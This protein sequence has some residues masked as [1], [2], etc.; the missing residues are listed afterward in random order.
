M[1]MA[2]SRGDRS[3]RQDDTHG[4][5]VVAD[6][7]I[8]RYW[9]NGALLCNAHNSAGALCEGIAIR[10]KTK[11]RKHGGLSLSGRASPTYKHGRYSKDLLTGMAAR[12]DEARG[13]PE[14]LSVSDDIALIEARIAEVLRQLGTGESGAAWQDLQRTLAEFQ[15]ALARGDTAGMN[16]HFTQMQQLVQAGSGTARA[17]EELRRLE[18][19]RCKLVQTE[20]KTLQGLQQLITIQQHLLLVSA[21]TEAVVQAVHTHADTAT[22]RKI[23][24]A[25]QAEFA[26]LATLE[27]R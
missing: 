5:H 12:V 10:G 3:H 13:N 11:C 24:M 25:V 20:M 8:P 21:Q 1:S 16:T 7:S 4:Q 9:R 2:A 23:L 6:P 15:V 17:W 27:T 26:R 22:G 14:L 18:E 19:T